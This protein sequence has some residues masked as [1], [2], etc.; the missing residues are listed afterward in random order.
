MSRKVIFFSNNLK[1]LRKAKGL[2]QGGLA[3]MIGVKANTI[4]NYES[5]SSAPDIVMIE[6][7]VKILDVDA[8]SL[9]YENLL[10]KTTAK[11]N[12]ENVPE[13]VPE[14]VPK[15]KL[16]I[17]GTNKETYL[18]EPTVTIA[19]DSVTARPSDV[20]IIPMV[21]VSSAA[22]DG[23]YNDGYIE[24]KGEIA[25]PAKLLKPGMHE[26]INISG[27]SMAPT[28]QDGGYLVQRLL[29][30]S[31]W[32]NIRTD[33]VYTVTDRDGVTRT[34]R[35]RNRLR[36]QGFIVLTSDNPDKAT[37][38]N[39]NLREDQIHNVWEVEW[40]LSA[41]MPNIH[42]TYYDQ[43]QTLRDDVDDIKDI[44]NRYLIKPKKKN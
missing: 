36:E 40:Y 12:K 6:K 42:A 15:P 7:I 39:K 10:T 9:L 37:Y 41:K 3:E 29:D 23:A 11:G 32:V 16:H 43:V 38:P 30:R 19:S 21:T 17:K 35:L 31:E 22:G 26:C 34:K 33:Y 18:D 44:L 28:L 4:S 1:I 13:N 8:H 5:G 20:T 27:D 25:L 2:T 14:F 24:K